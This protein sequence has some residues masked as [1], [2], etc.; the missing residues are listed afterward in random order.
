MKR[1]V[2]MEDLE[3]FFFFFFQVNSRLENLNYEM[4]KI[5]RFPNDEDLISH[6]KRCRY[7]SRW[8]RALGG[9]F[10]FFLQ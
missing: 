1:S 9:F 3:F 2:L 5:E 6:H 10:F 7:H 4:D 8:M